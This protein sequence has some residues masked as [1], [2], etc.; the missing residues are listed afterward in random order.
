MR[1]V[2]LEIPELHI[3]RVLQRAARGG[4]S[5]SET[6]LRRILSSS[7]RNL[8]AALAPDASGIES[9]RIYDNSR[10]GNLRGLFCERSRVESSEWL[11]I[12]RCGFSLL[13]AG[14]PPD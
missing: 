12:F 3:G 1:Y 11:T 5:A 2:A 13:S 4:H 8:P 10:F 6:T 9:V 7:L 14:P